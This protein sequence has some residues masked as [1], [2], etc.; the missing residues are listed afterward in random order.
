M[1]NNATLYKGMRFIFIESVQILKNQEF[2]LH[3]G[4]FLK[5]NV[6]LTF[7]TKTNEK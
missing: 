7:Y 6:I 2:L 5:K 4:G 3:V 1:N